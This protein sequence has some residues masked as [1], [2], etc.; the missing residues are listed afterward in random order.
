MNSDAV[1]FHYV[2]SPDT[3]IYP[4][5]RTETVVRSGIGDDI[6]SQDDDFVSS[7]LYRLSRQTISDESILRILHARWTGASLSNGRNN[8]AFSY[9]GILCKAG[10]ERSAAESFVAELIPDLPVEEITHASDYAY[11][12]N[13][14]GCDRRNYRSRRINN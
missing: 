3:V 4:E 9:L 10:I 14:F 12:H 11:T 1:P 6:V 7:F 2:P 13:L 5:H 8:T